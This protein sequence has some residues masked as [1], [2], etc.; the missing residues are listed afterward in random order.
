MAIKSKT[1]KRIPKNRDARKEPS[2]IEQ[3]IQERL[4]VGVREL[5]QDASGVLRLVKNGKS[6]TITE[7]GKPIAQLTPLVNPVL[8]DYVNAGVITPAVRKYDP[9][10]D[11]PL[12]N[13]DG[14]DLVAQLLQ[15]RA[16]I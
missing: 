12:P 16:R 6:I 5:R 14:I 11:K 13:P 2:M 9:K 3:K 7:H 10:I 1:K 4:T 15:D 8:S